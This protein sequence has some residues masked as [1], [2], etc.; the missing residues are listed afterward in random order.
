MS[1]Q[2]FN[3]TSSQV[4]TKN[5]GSANQPLPRLHGDEGGAGPHTPLWVQLCYPAYRLSNK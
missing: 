2:I 5:T 1:A 3:Q 4:C